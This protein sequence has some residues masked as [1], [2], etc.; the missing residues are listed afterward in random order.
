[1]FTKFFEEIW[2]WNGFIIG[3]TIFGGIANCVVM[4]LVTA[5]S[6]GI[7][8]SHLMFAMTNNS[9]LTAMHHDDDSSPF[10]FR[11]KLLNSN[12]LKF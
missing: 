3:I 12:I 9:T 11:G 1:M 10:D 5:L 4:M 6:A 8:F 7:A 2:E